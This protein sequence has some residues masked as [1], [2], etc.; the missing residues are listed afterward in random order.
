MIDLH[1]DTDK[2]T[3][4]RNN[5]NPK[6][7]AELKTKRYVDDKQQNKNVGVSTKSSYPDER[8]LK[9]PSQ[10]KY[11]LGRFT[12]SYGETGF[13]LEMFAN[14][15]FQTLP[16]K[17][18]LLTL[19]EGTTGI[20]S[21]ETLTSIFRDQRFPKNWHRRAAPA[22]FEIVS[23]T[24]GLVF[25]ETPMSVIPGSNDNGVFTP[26]PDL[27]KVNPFFPLSPNEYLR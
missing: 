7:M 27:T 23:N 12:L 13:T 14:G 24:T 4:K 22:S 9:I 5:V 1:G 10:M 25:L 2:E 6:V 8:T 26:D 15:T 11:D 3:G 19:L 16:F 20:L 18:S 17:R 21:R